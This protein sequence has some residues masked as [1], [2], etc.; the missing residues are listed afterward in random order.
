MGWKTMIL[1]RNSNYRT[2]MCAMILVVSNHV[3]KRFNRKGAKV[4]VMG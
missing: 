4:E 1:Y 3:G 2:K